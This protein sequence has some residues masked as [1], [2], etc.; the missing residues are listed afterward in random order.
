MME[1]SFTHLLQAVGANGSGSAVKN[2]HLNRSYNVVIS[3][4][5][6][7]LLEAHN[8]DGDWG[9]LRTSPA[10]EKFTTSE[11]WAYVRGTVSGYS[12]GTVTLTMGW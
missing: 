2:L 5:A 9:T 4:T 6:N 8:G 11:A 10:S 12:S 7:C 3:G 1:G